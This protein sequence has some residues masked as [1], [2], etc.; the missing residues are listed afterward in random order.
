ME[1][2]TLLSTVSHQMGPPIEYFDLSPGRSESIAGPQEG[3]FIIGVHAPGMEAVDSAPRLPTIISNRWTVALEGISV[4]GNNHTFMAPR[5]NITQPGTLVAL[6]DSG[7]PDCIVPVD[8]LDFIYGN[9]PGSLKGS[10]GLWYTPCL[11][12]AN[13][14]LAFGQVTHCHYVYA[15]L[16]SLRVQGPGISN[17]PTGFDAPNTP[18]GSAGKLE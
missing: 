11:N 14:T 5:S 1:G 18:R 17:T 10:D 7:T 4:N 13:V 8:V 2:T 6:L 16:T 9:I 12:S 3:S 15:S